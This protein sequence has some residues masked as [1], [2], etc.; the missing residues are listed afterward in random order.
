MLIFLLLLLAL[1]WW[2]ITLSTYRYTPLGRQWMFALRAFAGKPRAPCQTAA[3]GYY[4]STY[5][6]IA[7]IPLKSLT[8]LAGLDLAALLVA[9]I[10]ATDVHDMLYPEVFAASFFILTFPTL[11]KRKRAPKAAKLNALCPNHSEVET[12][13]AAIERDLPIS[14]ADQSGF[15]HP[16]RGEKTGSLLA[17]L[18]AVIVSVIPVLLGAAL[19][20]GFLMLFRG[21][22][23]ILA[24]GLLGTI[25]MKSVLRAWHPAMYTLWVLYHDLKSL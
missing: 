24:V 14:S 15:F 13:L 17:F 20:G 6:R 8:V 22:L 2:W 5:Q 10:G 3:L 25:W 9:L 16:D 21:T 1:P 23:L 12:F 7:D 19:T 11:A 18:F 4:Q